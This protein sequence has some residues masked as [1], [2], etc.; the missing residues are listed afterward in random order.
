MLQ[1]SEYHWRSNVEAGN[2][3]VKRVLPEKIRAKI[4]DAQVNEALEK[5]VAYNL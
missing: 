2:S 5:L 1:T 3:A 4:F